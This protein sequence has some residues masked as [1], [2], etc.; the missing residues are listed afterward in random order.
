MAF[1]KELLITTIA[2]MS[3]LEV[4]QYLG[5]NI[6]GL[7]LL[8]LIFI[9]LISMVITG[10]Y[11]GSLGKGKFWLIFGSSMILQGIV[12]LVLIFG[13]LPFYTSVQ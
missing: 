1:S 11:S 13:F 2:D 4:L 7:S 3:D 10:A 6:Y 9:P 8:L 12:L 5:I